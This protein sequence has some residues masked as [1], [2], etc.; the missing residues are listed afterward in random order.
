M[1]LWLCILQ[2]L[3]VLVNPWHLGAVS[4]WCVSVRPSFLQQ[5]T[6]KQQNNRFRATQT[7]K[8]SYFCEVL[9]SK[10]IA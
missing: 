2:T 1:S 8:T 3:R 9:C 4:T 7:F 10:V 5:R 6:I